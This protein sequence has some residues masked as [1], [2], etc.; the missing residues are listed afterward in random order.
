[1]VG[2]VLFLIPAIG[3]DQ[4]SVGQ[5]TRFQVGA[6]FFPGFPQ[7]KFRE[8]VE[9]IGVGVSGQFLYNIPH[10]PLHIGLDLGFLEYGRTS[11]REPFS[12]NIP[13][14]LVD[15]IT[16]NEIFMTHFIVRFQRPDGKLRP[17]FSALFG[18]H[19]LSTVTKI[20]SIND[21]GEDKELARYTNFDDFVPGAGISVGTLV[22]LA[23]A[24]NMPVFEENEPTP[25]KGSLEFL[26]D[27]QGL[28]L[29]GGTA[30]YLKE[31]SITRSNGTITFDVNSSRTDLL[32]V[33]IGLVLRF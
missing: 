6:D 19:Y 26:L 20:Q 24:D 15:V 18:G 25:K 1:M 21:V 14:V 11:R 9:R 28:Y 23:K 13:D 16:T 30:E 32:L 29:L 4:E 22:L 8:N 2:L 10:T 27:L 7:G 12:S 5:I 17:Y 33:E 31:G 3:F